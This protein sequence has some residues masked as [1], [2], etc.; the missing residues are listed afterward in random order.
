MTLRG[1]FDASDVLRAAALAG[2]RIKAAAALGVRDAAEYVLGE[3]KD[4][5][6]HE[7]GRLQNSGRVS[8]DDENLRATISFDTPYAVVQHENMTYR[9]DPGRSAKYLEIPLQSSG[10]QVRDL[11]TRR[12]A[13]ELRS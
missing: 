9:H 4:L 11:I 13:D 8:V 2:E 12:I 5:V 3:A 7:T 6:P 1:S 10:Q